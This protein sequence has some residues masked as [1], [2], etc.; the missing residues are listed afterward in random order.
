MLPLTDTQLSKMTKGEWLRQLLTNISYCVL[1][2]I[3][4]RFL[5]IY[6]PQFTPVLIKNDYGK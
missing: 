3:N 4:V 6:S 1:Y 5:F 2:T